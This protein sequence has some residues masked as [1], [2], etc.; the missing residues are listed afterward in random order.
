[1]PTVTMNIYDKW[2]EKQVKGTGFNPTTATV[3]CALVTSSYTPNQNTDEF[4]STP[5]ANEV[6]G[7]NYT[8][9]GNQCS[10]GVVSLSGAGVVTL[11]FNDPAAWAESGSGFSNAQ[12]VIIYQDSG[13]AG[14]SQLIAYSNLITPAVGN[15]S[16]SLTVT[17]DAAGLITS[18]R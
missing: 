8:A 13:V 12:R 5:Q 7:T 1:M 6:S 9:G 16:G 3:K 14:T 4:W 10:T 18:S 2:R 11:D 15:V 17:L